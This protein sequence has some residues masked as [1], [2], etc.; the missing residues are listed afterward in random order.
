MKISLF[1]NSG[2]EVLKAETNLDKYQISGENLSSGLYFF[3]II[4]SKTGETH[5]G[6]IAIR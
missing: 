1:D 4:N 6:K 5:K 2:K 3:Q